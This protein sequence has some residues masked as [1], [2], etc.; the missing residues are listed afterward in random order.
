MKSTPTA[1]LR[2]PKPI[3]FGQ[4]DYGVGINDALLHDRKWMQESILQHWEQHESAT[5]ESHVVSMSGFA[6]FLTLFINMSLHATN[7]RLRIGA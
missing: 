2:S 5:A 1:M 4:H 7:T 3:A 6:W